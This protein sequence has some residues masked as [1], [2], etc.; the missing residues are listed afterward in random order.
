MRIAALIPVLL[1]FLGPAFAA[2]DEAVLLT[3][4]VACF[5]HA[6]PTWPA[7]DDHVERVI[8]RG[9]ALLYTS[10][11]SGRMTRLVET[12]GIVAV[13][14]RRASYRVTRLLGIASDSERLYVLL[15]FSGRVYDRPPEEGAAL[16]GGRYEMRVFWLGDGGALRSPPLGPSGLPAAAPRASLGVG[17]LKIVSDGVSCFGRTARYDGRVLRGG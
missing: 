11:E 16:E 8:G 7:R 2:D 10:R 1:A 15:W 5:V 14:T 17:P 6:L 3:K 4:H 12:T 13:N 9:H